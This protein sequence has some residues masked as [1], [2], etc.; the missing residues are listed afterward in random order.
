MRKLQPK[1]L[2][3]GLALLLFN[4]DQVAALTI[5]TT[6]GGSTFV[7]NGHVVSGQSLAVDATENVLEAIG[8][9]FGSGSLGKAFDLFIKDALNGGSTLFS[10]SFV[11]ASGL[12]VINV[13]QAMTPSSVIYAVIDYNGH[14]TQTAVFTDNLYSGGS[15]FFSPDGGATFALNPGFDHRFV[16]EF[17]DGT[18]QVP[19]P[20][21]LPLFAAGLVGLELMRRRRAG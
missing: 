19:V 16:A 18:T 1:A 12:N 11:V 4:A 5:D 9:L 13:N 17:S 10:S 21:L 15:S 6:S 7:N 8:F 14:T 20:P 3:A 2:F